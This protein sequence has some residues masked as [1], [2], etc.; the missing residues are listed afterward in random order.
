M[1]LFLGAFK[2]AAV[3]PSSLKGNVIKLSVI[4]TGLL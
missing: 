4:P 1:G 3:L 2:I